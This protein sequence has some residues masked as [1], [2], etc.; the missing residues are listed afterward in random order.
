VIVPSLSPSDFLLA[1][2]LFST[3]PSFPLTV[4]SSFPASTNLALISLISL[5]FDS[6]ASACEAAVLRISAFWSS[7]RLFQFSPI[8]LL[9]ASASLVFARSVRNPWISVRR[10]AAKSSEVAFSARMAD[11]A[12]ASAESASATLCSAPRVAARV[13]SIWVRRAVLYVSSF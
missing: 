11:T 7:N 10:E 6:I 12:V 13:E 4:S 9:F 2:R 8:R 1:S 3:A 5:S